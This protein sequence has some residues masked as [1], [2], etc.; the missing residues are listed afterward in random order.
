MKDRFLGVDPGESRIGIAISDETGTIAF[1]YSVIEH[2]SRIVDAAQITQI[3]DEN[4]VQAIVV[5]IALDGDGLP[6]PQA[7]KAFRLVETIRSQTNIPVI[8]WDESYSTQDA[9]EAQ[10][11]LNIPVRKRKQRIDSLAAVIILRSFL[12]ENRRRSERDR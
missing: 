2:V 9:S 4:N 1:S 6:G 3:A 11:M 7:R 5:G 10:S 12:E 8:P